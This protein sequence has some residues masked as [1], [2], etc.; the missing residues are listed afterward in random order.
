MLVLTS[1]F[2]AGYHRPV[3]ARAGGRHP[4][5]VG[6]HPLVRAVAAAGECLTE[7]PDASAADSCEVLDPEATLRRYLQLRTVL[8][9]EPLPDAAVESLIRRVEEVS[10]PGFDE[11]QIWGE[12]QLCLSLIH[13]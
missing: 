10:E 13:I 9:G 4:L 2:S 1:W 12:W 5:V 3:V 8:S 11:E 6:R 7:A